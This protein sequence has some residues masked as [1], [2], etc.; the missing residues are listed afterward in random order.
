MTI[1]KAR[2]L[3]VGTGGI[4]AMSAYALEQGGKAEVTAVL[5]S[6]YDVVSKSGFE[7]DSIQ[8]GKVSGFKPAN[9]MYHPPS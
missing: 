4:G 3:V 2:V 8:Y 5:R 7:I 9:S 6:N 1:K